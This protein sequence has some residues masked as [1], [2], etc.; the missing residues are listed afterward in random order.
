MCSAKNRRPYRRD[1]AATQNPTTA[2]AA[3]LANSD[4]PGTSNALCEGL[5]VVGSGLVL[6][7]TASAHTVVVEPGGHVHTASNVGVIVTVVARGHVSVVAGAYTVV[8]VDWHVVN[9]ASVAYCVVVVVGHEALGV[10]ADVVPAKPDPLAS[11]GEGTDRNRPT[12]PRSAN[13]DPNSGRIGRQHAPDR[14]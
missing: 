6:L 10:V 4:T 2:S 13:S 1:R 3:R 5:V 7:V 14:I 9:A 11:I 12:I 8:V